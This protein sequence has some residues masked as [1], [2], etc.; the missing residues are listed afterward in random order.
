M[1]LEGKLLNTEDTWSASLLVHVPRGHMKEI[2]RQMTLKRENNTSSLYR[3]Q[4]HHIEL[5]ALD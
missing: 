5:E 3:N 1:L 2:T 4:A